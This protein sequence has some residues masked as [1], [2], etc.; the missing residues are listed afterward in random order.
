MAAHK[1]IERE[2][3]D[4]WVEA[5]EPLW[6]NEAGDKLV[7]EGHADAAS[8]F[9]SAG[10][11]ISR[12]DAIRFGLVKPDKADKAALAEEGEEIVDGKIEEI[13][14][15]VGADPEKVEAALAAERASEKPRKS[16]I[17]KLEKI[18]VSGSEG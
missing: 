2:S 16:L 6:L 4:R 8:L 12:E 3:H 1:V 18:D 11:R 13:L 7:A 14:A 10:K 5:A 17:S 15:A 9:A